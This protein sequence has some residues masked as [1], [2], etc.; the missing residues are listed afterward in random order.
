MPEKL[1]KGLGRY[2][3]GGFRLARPRLAPSKVRNWPA[4]RCL[5]RR[6]TGC[7]VASISGVGE[8]GPS[9]P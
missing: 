3:V 8:N 4:N 6:R 1:R 2:E 5:P 9:I 7:I